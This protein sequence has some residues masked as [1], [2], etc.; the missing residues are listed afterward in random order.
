MIKDYKNGGEF[1]ADNEKYLNTDKN[2]SAFFFLDAPLFVVQD[3]THYAFAVSDGESKLLAMK[4]QPYDLML[5]G[6][7]GLVP[8]AVRHIVSRGG[9]IGDVLCEE[10]L[11]LKL[12]D[13]VKE[14]YGWTYAEALAMDF[15][16]ARERTAPSSDEVVH[17]TADDID[18]IFECTER[19]VADCG[20]NDEVNR[21]RL[22]TN[23]D[24]FRCVRRD[25]KIA[26]MAK[27]ACSSDETMRIVSV[28]TRN[29]YRGQGLA[30]KVVNTAKNEILDSGC[31]AVLNVDRFNPISYHLYSSLGFYRL[32]SQG[33][34]RHID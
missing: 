9:R 32:F 6:D 7:P 12:T 30:R 22:L 4:V 8:E 25:G 14:E 15:M 31:V 3:D 28:Y 16:E 10:G 34:F 27:I 26:S 20:L 11:G 1:I 5:F 17:A 18:E 29:E 23:I 21:E 33:E 2:L 19:F 24:S 13:F